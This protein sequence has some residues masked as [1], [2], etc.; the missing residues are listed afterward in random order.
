MEREA[1]N[2]SSW[3][4]LPRDGSCAVAFLFGDAVGPCGGL[5]HRHHVDPSDPDSRSYQACARHH[6]KV[7]AVIRRLT[8][9]PVWRRCPHRPGTHRYQSGLEACE[10]QLNRGTQTL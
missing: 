8:T 4:E 9:G 2:R 7:Q 5:M 6:P 3:R 1:Y 10:R